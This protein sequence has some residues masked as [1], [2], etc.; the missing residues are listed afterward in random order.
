MREKNEYFK[1]FNYWRRPKALETL[2]EEE[3]IYKQIILWIYSF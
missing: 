3:T 2:G 1:I